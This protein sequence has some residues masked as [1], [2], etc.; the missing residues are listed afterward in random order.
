MVSMLSKQR[1]YTMVFNSNFTQIV[2]GEMKAHVTAAAAVRGERP[3]FVSKFDA[4]SDDVNDMHYFLF[5]DG[6]ERCAL[7]S[8]EDERAIFISGGAVDPV[9]GS[10][11]AR[12]DVVDKSVYGE[13]SLQGCSSEITRGVTYVP[14]DSIGQQGRTVVASNQACA[15]RCLKVKGCRF[16]NRWGDGGCHLS[17]ESSSEARDYNP[18]GVASGSCNAGKVMWDYVPLNTMKPVCGPNQRCE[19]Q[20]FWLRRAPRE[21]RVDQRLP[22]LTNAKVLA[23]TLTTATKPNRH[24]RR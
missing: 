8:E 21:T 4:S 16:W 3:S 23:K 5:D 14:I 12:H 18:H 6:R 2:G 19:H 13:V 20:L 10:M 17:S 15:Q 9:A 11:N 24:E 1:R 22:K 7:A